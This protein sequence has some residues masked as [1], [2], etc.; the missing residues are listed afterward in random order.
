MYIDI[1]SHFL[2]GVD[3]GPETLD[4]SLHMLRRAASSG[5]RAVVATPHMLTHLS[6]AWEETVLSHF[7]ETA[8]AVVIEKLDID[9]YLGSEIFFQFGL[10]DLVEWSIGSYRGL[11]RYSLVE[12]SM[13]QYSRHFPQALA[14]LLDRGKRPIFAH[15]ERVIPLM[16]DYDSI[17]SLVSR[18]VLM[19]VTA[20]SLLGD[21]GKKISAFSWELIGR[22]LVHFIA[23]DA[24]DPTDRPFNLDSAWQAVS[25]RFDDDIADLLLFHNPRHILFSEEIE[26]L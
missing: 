3:D 26:R 17:S 14:N 9:I 1:H 18:G 22:K 21:F 20:G 13:S 15:P 10:E 4:V 11:G 24:H 16:E 8:R 23:S 2:H 5:I 7:R 12:V 25:E 6:P 19:Q